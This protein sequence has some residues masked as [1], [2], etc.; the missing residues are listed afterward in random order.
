MEVGG[1]FNDWTPSRSPLK[2]VDNGDFE[3]TLQLPSGRYR[4]RL[5]VD[6][7]WLHDTANPVAEANEFGEYNSVFNID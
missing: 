4:Y 3:T 5:V 7:R 2:R 1:D 6:G